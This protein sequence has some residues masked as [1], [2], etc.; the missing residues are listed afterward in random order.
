MNQSL[1]KSVWEHLS[2]R[3]CTIQKPINR[4]TMRIVWLGSDWCDSLLGGVYEQTFI[5][6]DSLIIELCYYND[7]IMYFIY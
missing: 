3:L 1:L 2:V 6:Y 4:F 7:V 5:T